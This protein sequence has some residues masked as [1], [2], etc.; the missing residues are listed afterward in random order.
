MSSSRDALN[1]STFN[2][3]KEEDVESDELADSSDDDRGEDAED[4]EE[5]DDEY[6]NFLKSVFTTEDGERSEFSIDDDDDEYQPMKGSDEEDDDDVEDD[7]LV[8]VAP[9]EL[10]DLVDGCWQTRKFA[11]FKFDFMGIPASSGRRYPIL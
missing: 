9:K 6:A 4:T 3:E 2:R 5:V 11:H 1:L 10:V 7:D 8:Q